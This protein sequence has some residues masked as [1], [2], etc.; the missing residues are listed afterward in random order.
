MNNTGN[1]LIIKQELIYVDNW[2][3]ERNEE[4]ENETYGSNKLCLSL[5]MKTVSNV[6]NSV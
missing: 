1:D 4:Y 6:N 5:T 3:G 2:K